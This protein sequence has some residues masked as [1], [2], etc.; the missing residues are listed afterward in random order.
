MN[1]GGADIPGMSGMRV[2]TGQPV[3]ILSDS[4]GQVKELEK[5]VRKS[6][7]YHDLGKLKACISQGSPENPILEVRK[8]NSKG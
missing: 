8:G 5:G 6:A 7:G 2:W 3:T 4:E 1:T